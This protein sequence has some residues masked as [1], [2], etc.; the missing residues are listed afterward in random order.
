MSYVRLTEPSL[1]VGLVPRF[2]ELLLPG[3]PQ[4]FR[5]LIG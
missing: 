4:T 1:T 3:P 2:F 5:Q